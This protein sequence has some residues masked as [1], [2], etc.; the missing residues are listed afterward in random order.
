MT[1][2]RSQ[3]TCEDGIVATT[4]F[5]AVI[6][7]STSKAAHQMLPDVSNGRLAMLL[8]GESVCAMPAEATLGECCDT[9]T[10]A[11]QE[12]YYR[13]GIDATRLMSHPEER[14]T[15]SAAIFSLYHKELWLIGDCQCI[16]DG[17][18]HDNPKPEEERIARERS[19]IIKQMLSRGETDVA[20]LQCRDIGRERIVHQI[21][22]TCHD[23][24][25]EFAVFDGFDVAT[26]KVKVLGVTSPCEVVMA[27][28]GY[29]FLHPTLHDSESALIQQLS[30]DLLC[31]HTFLATKGRMSGQSSYDDRAYV[32]FRVIR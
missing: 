31:I 21:V 3:G 29:P 1:G 27:T 22:R 10:T 12:S 30:A 19:L 25:K 8:V 9:I 24:N 5:V 4:D 26:D 18:Y 32:R 7:G 14:L 2:K 17:E 23:Q 20:S 6:D 15:A 13:H 28:D 16:I 11:I